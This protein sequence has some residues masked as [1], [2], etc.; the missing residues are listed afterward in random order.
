MGSDNQIN[1]KIKILKG[2]ISFFSGPIKNTIPHPDPIEFN[3]VETIIKGPNLKD[4][5]NK[6][7]AT[8]QK[9]ERNS[10][11]NTLPY[12]TPTGIFQ[13]RKDSDLL[14]DSCIIHVDVDY[15]QDDIDNLKLWI[16]KYSCPVFMF[17]SPSGQGLKVFYF[18]DPQF[19]RKTYF[20]ALQQFFKQKFNISIDPAVKDISRACFMAHDPTVYYN[21][22]ASDL[23]S[24]FLNKWHKQES[25]HK[26]DAK[27]QPGNRNDTIM[28]AAAALHRSGISQN[29]AW[30]LLR[31]NAQSDFTEKEIQTIINSIY[32]HPERGGHAPDDIPAMLVKYKIDPTKKIEKPRI[33][34]SC[35]DSPLAT[36]GNCS[37]II[38]KAK[39]KKTF[40]I[41]SIAA[42]AICG[43][44]SISCI[45]G[46]LS[47]IDVILID[48]EQAP[49][50]LQ[51]TVDRIIRQTGDTIPEN[52]TAY[53]LRPLKALERVQIIENIVNNLK[54]PA[55]IIIDG[56]RDLLTQ[57]INDES[58]ATEIMSKILRWTYEKECHIM[59]VLHQNKG[60]F[61][62]RG[63]IGAEATNKSETVLSVARDQ[64]NR[65][66]SIVT[67]EYCRDIDFPPFCFNISEEGLP[68]ETDRGESL[69]NRKF[70]QIAENFTF[71]LPGIR[72]MRYTELVQQ[73]QEISGKGIATAKNHVA[74]AL[75]KKMLRQDTN[76]SYRMNT[77]N[78][79]D[80]AEPF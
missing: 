52:F 76:G 47:G 79:E 50:H 33:I 39:T 30:E 41:T 10:I 14:S 2:K 25:E 78:S 1:G 38:G 31:N 5:T 63:H 77:I 32:S 80:E 54:R 46:E 21:P 58:E 13:S 22:G 23:G 57:G 44:C 9:D 35:Q 55:L 45:T 16:K 17:R 27:F 64:R 53:G 24:E 3:E 74:E 7:R 36:I 6:I 65:D 26:T 70:D 12:I 61:N 69:Q 37:L 56:L 19:D 8:P 43:Q 29:L 20:Q 66:I 34:L 67:A 62:A 68:Y 73:Y 18:I 49:Y 4:I 75:K 60:D 42:A 48:T 71:I 40:L 59:L 11:K 51:R 72:S 28:K 15:Y